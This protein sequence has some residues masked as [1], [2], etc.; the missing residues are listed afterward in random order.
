[1]TGDNDTDAGF[2]TLLALDSS[3]AACSAAVWAQGRV[4][5]RRRT[6][7]RRGHAEALAPMVAAVLAEAGIAPRRLDAIAVT[8]G[9]GSFTGVRIGLA[10]ARGF[11]LALARPLIAL[12]T[13][14]V[15]AAAVGEANSAAAPPVLAAIEARRGQVYAQRFPCGPPPAAMGV[16]AAAA[17]AGDRPVRL[18]GDAAPR[19]AA[20]LG[21]RARIVAG[22]GQPDAAAALR[23]ALRRAP[24][25]APPPPLY[26]RAPDARPRGPLAPAAGIEPATYRLQDGCSSG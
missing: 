24:A 4:A 9:P 3:M 8:R 2:A 19:L 21:E 16:E 23:L 17:L 14:E 15:L 25:D 22:D 10:A 12:T 5:A 13:L 26:L 20:V 6:L 7:L 11:A 18:V 1:M